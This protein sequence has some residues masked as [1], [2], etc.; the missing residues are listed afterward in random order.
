VNSLWRNG[1][2]TITNYY[3]ASFWLRFEAAND[4]S[5]GRGSDDALSGDAANAWTKMNHFA[6]DR[7][8]QRRRWLRNTL[9][10]STRPRMQHSVRFF[11]YRSVPMCSLSTS[12]RCTCSAVR[13][14]DAALSHYLR[15]SGARQFAN[16]AP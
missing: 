11:E 4:I 6:A 10:V 3:V 9:Y 1:T 14:A 7:K 12:R 13:S 2:R 16:S 15:W 5:C 8:C